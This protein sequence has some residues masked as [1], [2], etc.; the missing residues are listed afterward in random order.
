MDDEGNL[1]GSY[2]AEGSAQTGHYYA[3]FEA[4]HVDS[5]ESLYCG[6]RTHEN[7]VGISPSP[8]LA[9]NMLML[10]YKRPKH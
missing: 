10:K 8:T 4:T 9:Q 3:N 1:P 6:P 2:E 7:F 5:Q